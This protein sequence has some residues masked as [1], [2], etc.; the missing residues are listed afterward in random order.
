VLD[1]MPRHVS[2]AAA[3]LGALFPLRGAESMCEVC[4]E[5]SGVCQE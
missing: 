4:V 2:G 5:G 1:A 3:A